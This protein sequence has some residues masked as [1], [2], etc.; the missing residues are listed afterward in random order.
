MIRCGDAGDA[1][2]TGDDVGGSSHQLISPHIACDRHRTAAAPLPP[3]DRANVHM[4]PLLRS[5]LF[6]APEFR[7]R[8]PDGSIVQRA[9]FIEGSK[10]PMKN[11]SFLLDRVQITPVRGR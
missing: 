10:Q 8:C 1:R 9:D 11:T 7:C 5:T 6:L 4:R 2:A 3:T